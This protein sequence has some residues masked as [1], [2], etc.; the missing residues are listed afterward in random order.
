MVC[1]RLLLRWGFI[2]VA[3]LGACSQRAP[4]ADPNEEAA[5]PDSLPGISIPL[6]LSDFEVVRADGRRGVFL[7]LS[8]LPD[9][10]THRSETDP[11]R[12]ILE[13]KGPTG[14]EEAEKSFPGG[15]T[16]VS[17]MRVSRQLGT[18]RI[19][20]DLLGDDLPKYSVHTMADWIMVRLGPAESS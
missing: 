9:S 13:I 1:G 5:V 11:A 8:R 4:L 6:G 17:Q 16:L 7:K 19:V 12:I 10:V 20:I 3:F 18:L 15:D 2:A 14:S